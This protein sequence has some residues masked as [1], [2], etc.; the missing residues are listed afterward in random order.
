MLC[1]VSFGSCNHGR[2]QSMLD[3]MRID[4]RLKPL[5]KE[6]LSRKHKKLS[7]RNL[8]KSM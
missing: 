6:K 4:V 8:T 2:Y 3:S 5:S 7:K 1:C